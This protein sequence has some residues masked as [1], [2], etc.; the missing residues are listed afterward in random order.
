MVGIGTAVC[1]VGLNSGICAS[2][3]KRADS[4]FCMV[5]VSRVGVIGDKISSETLGVGVV[6]KALNILKPTHVKDVTKVKIR[7]V[8]KLGNFAFC[9]FIYLSRVFFP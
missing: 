9:I 1:N 2:L 3:K 4:T 6:V 7:I 8:I 5:L